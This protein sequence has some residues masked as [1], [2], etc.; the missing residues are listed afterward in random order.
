MEKEV[1]IIG[2]GPSL[3]G[4]DWKRLKG[5]DTIGINEAYR[6][7]PTYLFWMDQKWYQ[8]KSDLSHPKAYTVHPVHTEYPKGITC[9]SREQLG[10]GSNSGY[11]SIHL[12]NYL[13]YSRVFL[14]GF[15]MGYPI[16]QSHWHEGYKTTAQ[17]SL[18]KS[19]WVEEFNRI[20]KELPHM[21]I[22][23]CNPQSN[24]RIFPFCGC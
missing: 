3:R 21:K 11:A 18:M 17:R 8:S 16:G 10:R 19:K 4:Y 14:L 5:K 6:K 2:G 9:L 7:D 15:D 20:P 12:A 13:G 23:N 24:L 1:Y 22:C